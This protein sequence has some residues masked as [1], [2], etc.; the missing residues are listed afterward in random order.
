MISSELVYVQL[1]QF[2]GYVCV[3][4]LAMMLEASAME[5]RQVLRDLGDLIEGNDNDQWRVTRQIAPERIL[6]AEERTERDQLEQ[7]VEQSFVTLGNALKILRDKRLYRE[8]HATFK[9]YVRDRFDY[10][11]RAADYLIGASEVVENLKREQIVLKSVV[12]NGEINSPCPTPKTNVLPTKESQCRCL[13]GH[14]PEIQLRAWNRALEI[15]ENQKIPPAR[16]VKQ[17]VAEVIQHQPGQEQKSALATEDSVKP[18]F[19]EVNYQ[20]GMGVEYTV[21][22]DESTFFRLKQYQEKIGSATK[23]GAIARLLDG[24]ESE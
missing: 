16:V 2:D 13:M 19:R 14:P 7:T 6:S 15:V 4:E 9:D 23:C 21:K 20:P 1:S 24:V 18:K 22:L 10:S 3:M 12:A 8:T 11:R 5:V 17:A